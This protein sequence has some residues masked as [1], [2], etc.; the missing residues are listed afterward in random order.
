MDKHKSNRYNPD[1]AKI[2]QKAIKNI[3][4]EVALSDAY[5]MRFDY[6]KSH[7]VLVSDDFDAES[8]DCKILS[9]AQR[10]K[11]YTDVKVLV[12]TDDLNLQARAKSEDIN[13]CTGTEFVDG[14]TVR[15]ID[16]DGN[17][18]YTMQ[19]ID[20]LK[21]KIRPTNGFTDKEVVLLKQ[22]GITTY[23]AFL[24]MTEAEFSCMRDKKGLS[25][26]RHFMQIQKKLL[27]ELER[28]GR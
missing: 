2:A 13:T 7:P 10:Y 9:V 15:K 27:D 14:R 17:G 23:E 8:N 12:V 4:R 6:E 16:F 24:D 1:L 5:P 18:E 28:Q 25:F 3:R 11:E 20:F 19:Q 21:T 26:E 22:Y